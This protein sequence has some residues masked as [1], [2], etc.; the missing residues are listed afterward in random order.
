M[1][2]A[3]PVRAWRWQGGKAWLVTSYAHLLPL[4]AKGRRAFDCFA[5][6]CVVAIHWLKLGYRVVIG[7]T[8]AR[9]IWTLRNLKTR[10]ED[11][12]AL[13]STIAAAY[14]AAPDQ[15]AD[16]YARREHLNRLDPSDI[17]AS[18]LFLFML[19]AGFNGIYRENQAGECNTPVGDCATTWGDP[20]NAQGKSYA[21]RGNRPFRKD[22]VQ[23]D[24]LRAIAALLARAEIRLGDFEET[25]ADARRGDVLFA[26]APYAGEPGKKAA[27]VGYSKRGFTP[28]DR[29][30]LAAWLRMLD[31]RGVRFT[32]TDA[33]HAVT[34]YGLW[35]VT[36]AMVR[37]SGSCKAEGRGQA[38]E[39]IVTN[40]SSQR[41][42]TT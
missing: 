24:D 15:K 38:K 37:R 39:I 2:V 8:N 32:S 17:G 9:L 42:A 10:T 1:T 5:G 3:A 13:L 18:A 21:S 28:R 40:F 25:T 30:R 34:T 6:S 19:R 12:I 41:E 14:Q 26:D 33:A 22:L 29:Q 11:V 23:A 16:F 4:P 7:D 27:F 20:L 36:P 31:A 35:N